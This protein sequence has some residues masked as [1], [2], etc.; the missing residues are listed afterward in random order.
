MY[1]II[2][3]FTMATEGYGD[4]VSKEDEIVKIDDEEY[5][6][7][8]KERKLYNQYGQE[9]YNLDEFEGEELSD[10]MV[11]KLLMKLLEG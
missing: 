7:S 11:K 3:F 6:I 9:L 8:Y 5:I 10:K 4:V 2:Q 1:N